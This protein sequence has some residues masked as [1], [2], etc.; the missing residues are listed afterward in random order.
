MI[1]QTLSHHKII[2]KQGLRG[3]G[4]VYK[5]EEISND[6]PDSKDDD[7]AIRCAGFKGIFAVLL[8]R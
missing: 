5:A 7:F 6:K 8:L 4:V 1:S 2:E 3:M